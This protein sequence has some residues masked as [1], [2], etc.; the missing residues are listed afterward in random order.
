MHE[1]SRSDRDQFIKINI[2][3]VRKSAKHNF[4]L[5]KDCDLQGLQYDIG[6]VMHYHSTAFTKNGKPTIEALGANSGQQLGQRDGFSAL[7]IEGINKIY[8]GESI[9]SQ[10]FSHI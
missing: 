9:V 8:C 5:C 7:D 10:N 4:A 2:D 6:S 3:N 1:Q